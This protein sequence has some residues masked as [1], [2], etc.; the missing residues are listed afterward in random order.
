KIIQRRGRQ[1]FGDDLIRQHRFVAI[2]SAASP[3]S[4]NL[5]F[6]AGG[7]AGAYALKFQEDFA[8]DTRLHQPTT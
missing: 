6:L 2:P 4:W 7:A 3:N 5:I 1:A 8:L